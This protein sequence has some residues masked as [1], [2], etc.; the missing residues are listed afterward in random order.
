MTEQA[1]CRAAVNRRC[2][3]NQHPFRSPR[4]RARAALPGAERLRR[5]D[6]SATS[7]SAPDEH[8]PLAQLRGFAILCGEETIVISYVERI[9]QP[10]EQI[11]HIS[12]IHWIVYWAGVGVTVLAAVA[13]WLSETRPLTRL[14]LYT[15]CALALVAVALLVQEWFTWWVTEIAVTNRRVIYK[16]GFIWRRTN[17]MNMDKVESVQVDQSILGRMLNYGTVTILGTGEGFETLRTIAGP[18]KPRNCIT[19]T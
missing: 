7:T 18:I 19:G 10:G 4:R 11:R 12:S 6:P 8:R 3:S 1:S 17:E 14:W 13:Y 15:A 2:R 5:V 9:L 16:K